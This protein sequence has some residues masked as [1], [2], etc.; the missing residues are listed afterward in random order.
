MAQV[1][2]IQTVAHNDDVNFHS[3][4]DAI[5]A[6]VQGHLAQPRINKGSATWTGPPGTAQAN[7]AVITLAYVAPG[8]FRVGLKKSVVE[9]HPDLAYTQAWGAE[10]KTTGFQTNSFLTVAEMKSGQKS[11]SN[12]DLTDFFAK[13]VG[14][15]FG[16]PPGPDL[17]QQVAAL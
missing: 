12:Q 17:F 8:Y 13:V 14:L 7:E 3:T 15:L 16:H 4:K 11:V 9:S 2:M 1:K 10:F 6:G 5:H